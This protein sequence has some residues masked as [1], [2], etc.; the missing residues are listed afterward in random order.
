MLVQ[1]AVPEPRELPAFAREDVH[2]HGPATAELTD[3]AVSRHEHLVEGQLG[4][5]VGAV[6]LLDRAHLDAGRARI[7]DE[8]GEPSV[9][10]L[11]CASAREH[12]APARIARPAGPDL[13]PR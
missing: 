2:R 12:E 5:L 4:E 6:R 13:A 1:E 11:E 3:D 8:R 9:A 7:D 10:R